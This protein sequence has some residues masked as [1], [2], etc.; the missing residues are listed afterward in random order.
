MRRIRAV[1]GHPLGQA[2]VL[3]VLAYLIFAFGIAYVPP[4]FGVPSAPVPKSVLTQ[5]MFIALVGIL[6]YVSTSD[7]SWRRFKEPLNETMVR[8]DRRWLRI[9][10]LVT[11]PALVGFATFAQVRPRVEA[12]IALRSIH[13]AP[14]GQITVRGRTVQLAGLANPLRSRGSLDEHV[15]TGRRV[16]Y[17]NCVPCHGDALDGRGH[18]AHGFNPAPLPLSGKGTIDQLTESFLFW[19][20]SKGGPGL[21]REGTPWNSAMPVWEDFLTD[22]EIWSVIIYLYQ[23]SGLQPRRWE[24]EAARGAP[25]AGHD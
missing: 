7:A 13:P 23:Q 3:L 16:Y 19:R 21:P 5:Y 10:A 24:T 15:R 25:A 18:F 1:F 8:R 20:I 2:F 22:D 12:P 17:E 11:L 9:L 4:L 6:L 14:P